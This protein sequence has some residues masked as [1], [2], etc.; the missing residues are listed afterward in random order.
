MRRSLVLTVILLLLCSSICFARVVK[1]YFR[2][3]K[4]SSVQVFNKNG[5][6]KGP[7]KVYWPN[8]RLRS[9]TIYKNG[10]LSIVHHWTKMELRLIRG[11]WI[12][13]YICDIL[14]KGS[15]RRQF[16]GEI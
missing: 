15:T 7:Y 10:Q 13:L 9:M 12:A 2:N 14:L 5:T 3:G 4:V 11:K 1:T 8:G 16:K 6:I